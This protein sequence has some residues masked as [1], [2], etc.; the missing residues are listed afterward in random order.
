[1]VAALTGLVAVLVVVAVATIATQAWRAWC[2]S[3]RWSAELDQS[4]L[5]LQMTGGLTL[6]GSSAGLPFCLNTLFSLYRARPYVASRSWLWRRCMH[7]LNK[8]IKTWAA[9]GVVTPAGF[10]KPVVLNR[11][12]RACLSHSEIR[13]IL[14]PEQRE[15]TDEAIRHAA[16]ES[17]PSSGQAAKG[18]LAG[19]VKLG[20][21]AE[22]ELHSHRCRH[23][24]QSLLAIGGFFSRRQMALNVVAVVVSVLMLAG[25][26][27][28]RSLLIPYAAPEVIPPSSP[29]RNYLWVS[30]ETQHPRYFT[31]ILESDFWTNRR[32]V[33]ASY[34]GANAS[35]RAEFP[36]RKF[37]GKTSGTEKM[38]TV[39]VERR[40]H[41]LWRE[42][43]PG[44]RVGR[45]TL[46]YL[47]TLGYQ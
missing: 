10:L 18:G 3:R 1:M 47:L 45:Y 32:A 44:E 20:F 41:F 17:N 25:A 5:H 24:A 31:V 35:V 6:Q 13:H 4:V 12:L 42:F 38:A 43:F 16:G 40:Q 36:L 37:S 9:T 19:A 29:S 23:A 14:V 33:V 11:K 7:T 27:D 30:I 26:R 34:S 39:W 15:G 46:P 21:A 2:V 8:E 22:P 28:V